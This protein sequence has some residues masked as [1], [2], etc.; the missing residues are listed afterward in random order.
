MFKSPVSKGFQIA[1]QAAPALMQIKDRSALRVETSSLSTDICRD[2]GGLGARKI[3]VRHFRMR[4][5][6]EPDRTGFGEARPL[7]NLLERRSVRV[8]L[9]LGGGNDVAR[10]AP[11]LGKPLAIEGVRRGCGLSKYRRNTQGRNRRDD[12]E[13]VHWIVPHC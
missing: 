11:A 3:H 13:L 2:I 5:E 12:M 9:A 7:R 8:G 1:G 10:R 6:Q 4:V